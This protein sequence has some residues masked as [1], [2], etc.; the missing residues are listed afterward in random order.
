MSVQ[1]SISK[2]I[3]QRT[4]IDK[5]ITKSALG[6]A[7]GV[8]PQAVNK[9]IQEGGFKIERVPELCNLLQIT[10]N[11][12]FEFT[13]DEVLSLEE[14]KIIEAYRESDMKPAVKAILN[15]K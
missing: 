12:L 3:K 6:T 15:V 4:E 5:V 11:E 8:T 9:W 2:M 13:S 14:K 7:L 10:P 1:E